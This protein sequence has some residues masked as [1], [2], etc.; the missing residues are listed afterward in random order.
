MTFDSKE[1]KLKSYHKR[2]EVEVAMQSAKTKT[3]FMQKYPNWNDIKIN[4]RPAD[5]E[6][7]EAVHGL[8]GTVVPFQ[9][10]ADQ[11]KVSRQAVFLAS[12]KALERLDKLAKLVK[13]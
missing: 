6:V 5:M 2:R 1:R 8:N 10:I 13:E 4:L 7:I 3:E 11:R 9:E 12:K